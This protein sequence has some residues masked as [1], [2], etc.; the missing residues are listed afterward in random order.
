M[1]VVT[2]PGGGE[3]PAWWAERNN[4]QASQLLNML[5]A[6][7]SVGKMGA[8]SLP[9][10]GG[11]HPKPQG[12]LVELLFGPGQFVWPVDSE[13]QLAKDADTL[14]QEE[15]FH[16]EKALEARQAADRGVQRR[17]LGR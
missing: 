2:G 15:K 7:K 5:E 12:L 8:P 17:G 3:V 4:K 6:A 10:V 9:H 14:G 11:D 1:G 16:E 13:T